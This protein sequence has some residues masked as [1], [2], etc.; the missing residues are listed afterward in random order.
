MKIFFIENYM[1]ALN[2]YGDITLNLNIN[3]IN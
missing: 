2:N 3:K 1:R